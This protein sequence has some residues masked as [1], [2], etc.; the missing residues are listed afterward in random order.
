MSKAVLITGCSTGIGRATALRLD[1]AGWK[2]F[3]GVRKEQDAEALAAAASDNLTPVIVD[4]TDSASIDLCRERIEAAA[5]DGVH[6][7][8]NNAGA[9]HVGPLEFVPVEDIRRQFEVNFIGQIAVT[10]AL[11]P[12]LRKTSGRIVNI[13][14]IG[15]LVATPFFG[16]YSASKY[17]FEAVSDCLRVELRPWGIE[18]I[19][20]EPGSIATEIWDSGGQIF[21]GL[22]ERLPPRALE[23]YEKA[24]IAT[25]RASA[26]TGARGIPADKAAA[27]IEKALTA[28]RPRARYLVGR[29]AYGMSAAKR[30]LPAKLH[31]RLTARVLKLP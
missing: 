25:A 28:E 24:M 4:V 29:D 18:T 17:A 5:P 21:A 6:G 20:I 15:G 19:A 2:V 3:A 14:S 26:E 16:P 30:I 31:D 1:S 9:A 12:S 22:Q 10:Q 23:F 8:V 11:I 7:L 27:V 13:T